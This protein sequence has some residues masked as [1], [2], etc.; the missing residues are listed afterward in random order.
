MVLAVV[1]LSGVLGPL[2]VAESATLPEYDRVRVLVSARSIRDVELTNQEGEPFRLSDLQGRAALVLFGFTNCPDVCPM[3]MERMRQLE[4]SGRLDSDKVAYVM[5]SVDGERDTPAALKAFLKG[6]SQRFIG[7]T[8][9]P[10]L[11]KPIAKDFS[12]AFYK[13][14]ETSDGGEYSV[15]HSPQIFVIDPAGQL[16]AEFYSASMEAMIGVTLALLDEAR[17]QSESSSE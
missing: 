17:I 10:A 2:F 9:K 14:N 12:A 1:V 15:L 5:I 6:F 8:A 11:V 4:A 3:A 13:G 7:L 16:R